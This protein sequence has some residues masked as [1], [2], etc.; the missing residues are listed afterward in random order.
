MSTYRALL[1]LIATM[2]TVHCLLHARGLF[3]ARPISSRLFSGQTNLYQELK[4]WRKR[5]ADELQKPLYQI[6]NNKLLED[7]TIRRPNNLDQLSVLSGV[8]PKTLTKFGR[9][10]LDIVQEH[11]LEEAVDVAGLLEANKISDTSFWD[12]WVKPKPKKKKVN[13]ADPNG[14]QAAAAKR[15]KRIEQLSDSAAAELTWPD[16]ELDDLN[17]EQR[18]AALH[19]L[20]GNNVF[21][22]GSAGT[23]KTF[24]LRYVIQEMVHKHG[25][26]AVAV[27]AP[28]GIAAINIGG[29]TLHRF[30][31]IGLGNGDP[32]VLMNKV[33]KSAAAVD[34]WSKCKVLIID[35]I[36]MLDKDLFELLDGIARKIH[37]NDCPFGGMQVVVVGDF[38]QLPPVSIGKELEF[39]FESDVWEAA[40]F[41]V[42]KGTMSLKQVERQKDR[43]FVKYL[44]EVR[45]GVMSDEFLQ[46]LEGCLVGKKP[47]P[48][49]GIIPTKLYSNN[50]EVDKENSERLT[51]LQ[52]E[53]VSV[54]AEDKWKTK[55]SKPGMTAFFRKALDAQ[56]PEMLELKLGAQ[57]MLLR[58]RARSYALPSSGPSLVNGSR[59]KVIG[60]S[61]SVQCPGM[62]VPTVQFD[63]GLT[64]TIGPVE[65]FYRAPGGDGE[66]IRYQVPLKLAWAA[67]IHKSQGCTLTC[68]ELMLENTF[69]FGQVYVALSRVKGIEGLWLSKPIRASSIKANPKVLKFYG[70]R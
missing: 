18:E 13:P 65:Y 70:Y 6:M 30:A 55:P 4:S 37:E 68:A 58:N 53:V 57:V 3:R 60:F 7:I 12:T 45:L 48:E 59:G 22:T 17:E 63:N 29:Q 8:G 11:S 26:E 25:E 52:G 46:L 21:L 2:A 1:V 69:D 10:I 40:A 56:V 27:T 51:E 16:I 5:T 49:H 61:E 32:A 38:M 23:G 44:N 67:T 66:I 39:C 36:S 35:E 43:H 33:M 62:Q 42:R 34:R 47:D 15:K 31:G 64:T 54:Q 19:I 14:T 41:N 20:E 24:L 28:T 50:R 9:N